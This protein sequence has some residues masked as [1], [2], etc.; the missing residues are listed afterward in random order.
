MALDFACAETQW[1][2][3]FD[4]VKESS[5]RATALPVKY[6]FLA[7][8]TDR[9]EVADQIRKVTNNIIDF[10]NSLFVV[11]QLNFSPQCSHSWSMDFPLPKKHTA[12]GGARTLSLE[13][14]F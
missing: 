1:Q 12:R 11:Q 9:I 14:P 2:I 6:R 4:T 5:G 3:A 7:R 13:I 8:Y 10:E